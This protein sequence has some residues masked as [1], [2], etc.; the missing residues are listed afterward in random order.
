LLSISRRG[1][2]PA[3]LPADDYARHAQRAQSRLRR[4]SALREGRQGD[5]RLDSSTMPR[6]TSFIAGGGSI[7]AKV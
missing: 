6:Q 1:K 3:L 7:D 2:G 4:A 5:R